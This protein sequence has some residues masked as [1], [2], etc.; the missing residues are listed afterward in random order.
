MDLSV[1]IVCYKGWEK[2][3]K[4][5][6]SLG[7]FTCDRFTM[8]VLVVDNN[9]GDGKLDAIEAKFN[10]FHFIRSGINGGYAYG[11]NLGAANASGEYLLIL[12][13]DTIV[14][15]ND[16]EK[17]LKN[18]R[19]DPGYYIISCRQVRE[20]N[21]ENKTIGS[22]PGFPFFKRPEQQRNSPPVLLPDWVSGSVMMIRKEIFNSLKGF[23]EDFWMY[24]EDVDI[25]KRARE[26][27]GDVA[28]FS[29][30]T[31]EHNHGGSSRINLKTT[32]ITKTEVQ[33]SRH[34]YF[35]K[36]KKGLERHLLHSL[37][38]ADNIITGIITGILGLALFFIP[39]LFVR[40]LIFIRLVSYYYGSSKR[41]SWISPRSVNSLKK[42]P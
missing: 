8:E 7:S 19:S 37:I 22:F 5:L 15:E 23:D 12:N 28:F 36:H 29:D 40:I 2:L 9:S 11:C 30:I 18:S 24:S 10:K 34:V 35:Q 6:E 38:I 14:K 4:C 20:N 25:C 39:K 42:F 3:L 27:G 13:P 21:K 33:I 17:L 41:K 31:I 16:V 32:S 1:I 26:A